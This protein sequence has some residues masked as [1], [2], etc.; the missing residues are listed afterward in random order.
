MPTSEKTYRIE[1]DSLSR[2]LE[3]LRCLDLPGM[4]ALAHQF[5]TPAERALIAAARAFL[6]TLP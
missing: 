2:C 6:L 1:M 4:E 5:G 3:H